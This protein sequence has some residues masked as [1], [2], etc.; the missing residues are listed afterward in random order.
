MADATTLDMLR[1]GDTGI[2]RRIK[3][4]SKFK[5]R[6]VEMG[7]LRRTV[8]IVKKFAPLRD[9]AEYEIN[10]YHVAIRRSE[11]ADIVME[12]SDDGRR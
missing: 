7:F 4:N 12:S 6:L 5:Q 2:I 10:G 11:A 1:A 9:P 3:G 8:L